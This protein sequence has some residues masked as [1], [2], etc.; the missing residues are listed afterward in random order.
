MDCMW[1]GFNICWSQLR[2][3]FDFPLLTKTFRFCTWLWPQHA[4]MSWYF[5]QR[6]W[7]IESNIHQIYLVIMLFSIFNIFLRKTNLSDNI[8]WIIKV[9]LNLF[10]LNKLFL[11]WEYN[12]YYCQTENNIEKK[13]LINRKIDW[14]I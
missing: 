6:F 7:P 4:K 14:V 3:L 9:K 13:H 12:S 5:C 1:P 10:L 2:F 11:L 8:G